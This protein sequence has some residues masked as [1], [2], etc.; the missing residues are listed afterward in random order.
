MRYLQHL[1]KIIGGVI[2]SWQ[3]LHL[4]FSTISRRNGSGSFIVFPI[5]NRDAL[6]SLM[7]FPID[8]SYLKCFGFGTATSLS[9]DELVSAGYFLLIDF[10][11]IAYTLRLPTFQKLTPK[12]GGTFTVNK[13]EQ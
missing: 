1:E 8:W 10:S 6:I 5:E 3:M 2:I 9:E 4:K 11:F 12:K 13:P 7:S